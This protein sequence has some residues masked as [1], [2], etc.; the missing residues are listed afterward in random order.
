[1]IFFQQDIIFGFFVL[2]KLLRSNSILLLYRVIFEEKEMMDV[3]Y[4]V[5]FLFR[6]MEYFENSKVDIYLYNGVDF[7]IKKYKIVYC[8]ILVFMSISYE[9]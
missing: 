8:R 7:K 5:R 4:Q 1:M 3:Q 2:N 9:F 6:L